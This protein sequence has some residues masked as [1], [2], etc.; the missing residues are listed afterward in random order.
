MC[1]NIHHSAKLRNWNDV[2]PLSLYTISGTPYKLKCP[3]KQTIVDLL[4]S[5]LPMHLTNL[6]FKNWSATSRYSTSLF[7]KKSVP[8]ACHGHS[9][10]S[11][12]M[13]GSFLL[14]PACFWQLLQLGM[15]CS[16]SFEM[17]L[18]NMLVFTRSQH[19]SHLRCAACRAS[20]MNSLMLLGIRTWTLP[21]GWSH[22]QLTI[23]HSMTSRVSA[24]R[25]P[26]RCWSSHPS[27]MKSHRGPSSSSLAVTSWSC[28]PFCWLICIMFK[29]LSNFTT[30]SPLA[31]SS[32]NNLPASTSVLPGWYW[33][34]TSS[35]WCHM[36]VFQLDHFELPVIKLY[37][38]WLTIQVC[39]ES[40]TSIHDCKQLL[41]DIGISWLGVGGGFAG[42]CYAVAILHNDGSQVFQ[43]VVHVK[44]SVLVHV[45][46]SQGGL[47]V[48]QLLHLLEG[49]VMAGC[50]FKFRVL[51][52]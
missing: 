36:E 42:E 2:Y 9:G 22:Y 20:I 25:Q 31:P 13:S 14:L 7:S 40:L 30:P 38:E 27:M 15:Y 43:R 12:G 50:P 51:L 47:S 5:E 17:P 37:S 16:M 11:F 1:Q 3:L 21:F 44:H 4:V 28:C 35:R 23:R 26:C 48:Y 24:T 18:Q 6:N 33:A 32:L 45:K 10:N 52:Q 46:V 39:L 49:F 34:R 8:M 29:Q 41:L 19:L